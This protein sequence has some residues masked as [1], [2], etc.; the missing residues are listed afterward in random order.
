MQSA[1]TIPARRTRLALAIS[2]SAALASL[3]AS[4]APAASGQSHDRADEAEHRAVVPTSVRITGTLHRYDAAGRQL[5]VRTTHDLKPILLTPRTQIREGTRA[6][7]PATLGTRLGARIIVRVRAVAGAFEAESLHI[8]PWP[9]HG[10]L[11]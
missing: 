4:A 5:V 10:D 2:L 6:L 11:P 3:A 1:R 7:A 9:P 8:V